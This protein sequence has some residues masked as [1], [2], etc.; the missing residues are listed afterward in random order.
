V[1]NLWATLAATR[2]GPAQPLVPATPGRG[3]RLAASQPPPAP[4]SFAR[5]TPVAEVLERHPGAVTILQRHGVEGLDDP[6]I[7][8]QL[9][10]FK[11]TLGS[12]ATTHGL[13]AAALV[14]EINAGGAPAPSPLSLKMGD[15]PRPRT[16]GPCGPE[17]IIG[18]V[19]AR[20]PE[21]T[22]IF[23]ERFGA[24]CFTCP[25][26]ATESIAQAAMMHNLDPTELVAAL[27]RVAGGRS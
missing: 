3:A 9:A 18:E 12:L 26:Q 10:R 7:L 6:K 23:Q 11:V 21:T 19:L 16:D 2:P 4:Y 25:G 1:A 22:A 5:D 20:Y 27:N 13:A 8:A 24:G 14:A 17:D 15:S